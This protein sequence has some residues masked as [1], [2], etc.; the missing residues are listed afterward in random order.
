MKKECNVMILSVVFLFLV[1]SIGFVSAASGV[2]VYVDGK[3]DVPD[4]CCNSDNDCCQDNHCLSNKDGT[5]DC[6]EL[7]NKYDYGPPTSDK[8]GR[9]CRSG[10]NDPCP[11]FGS[12]NKGGTEITK[13]S[14]RG[15]DDRS[16]DTYYCWRSGQ[17]K[18]Y[19]DG[20]R[21]WA[22]YCEPGC[23]PLTSEDCS[24]LGYECG[25]PYD[26][27]CEGVFNCGT[28]DSGYTCNSSGKCKIISSCEES[29]RIMKLQST[30]SSKGALWN[31]P[32]YNVDI[33][34]DDIFGETYN[35]ADP[36]GCRGNMNNP[37][38]TVVWLESFNNSLAST[39]KEEDYDVPVCYG[40]M[41]CRYTTDSCSSNEEVVLKLS[42]TTDALMSN[43]SG[44]YPLKICCK[45]TSLEEIYWTDNNN[46]KLG[47]YDPVNLKDLV[48]VVV[49]GQGLKSGE[50]N[51]KIKK[52]EE[53]LG[54]DWL[55]PDPI[56]AE[57]SEK[58]YLKW[59]AGENQSGN[60]SSGLYYSIVEINGIEKSTEDNPEPY[61]YLNVLNEEN[62]K[63]PSIHIFN[64]TNRGIYFLKEQ[65]N[66]T[67]IA[68]DPDDDF[69][70]TWDLG[71]GV[72]KTGDSIN[73]GNLSF[74][75]DY[76]EVDEL[77]QKN[78]IVEA[79]DERGAKSRDAVSILI[80]NSSYV[81]AYIDEPGWKEHIDSHKVDFDASG[82]YAVDTSW[83]SGGELNIEC[84]AGNCPTESAGCPQ[85]YAFT[86]PIPVQN[87]PQGYDDL[88]FE[89]IFDNNP[90][91]KIS[92]FG[93]VTHT[94]AFGQVG[95]HEVNLTV[96]DSAK[97]HAE[98]SL[99]FSF[100]ACGD[101]PDDWPGTSDSCWWEDD[102][103]TVIN[104][105]GDCWREYGVSKSNR[106]RKQQSCCP[107]ISGVEYTCDND[108]GSD[109]YGMCLGNVNPEPSPYC[110]A[111]DGDENSCSNPDNW[112]VAVDYYESLPAD[113][114]IYC[115][116]SDPRSSWIDSS[117]D[118][119][120]WYECGCRYDSESS[121]CSQFK[122]LHKDCGT[123][124]V[125]T[126]GRCIYKTTFDDSRCDVT[127]FME[128]IINY[129]WIGDSED[130]PLGCPID[131]ARYQKPCVDSVRLSFFTLF[132]FVMALMSISMIYY[133]I[134]ITSKKKS[135][136][137]L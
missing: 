79:V 2:W 22:C 113:E 109:T 88:Y 11:T 10:E 9:I 76:D 108:T 46:T 122:E 18:D 97:T 7:C 121:N 110:S 134:F 66:F 53:L 94:R 67:L 83:L 137:C 95:N 132:N 38:N 28:C 103:L 34:Y 41:I 43:R 98:F 89:W 116:S 19:D 65:I 17:K 42:E 100:P 62:N 33:C 91:M 1:I 72:K 126:I 12:P 29:Q 39:Q 13:S 20:D 118:C 74:I 56:I 78:I 92:G 82:T 55:S 64:L 24:D 71:N 30:E 90:N 48:R 77:G 86:C 128:E 45:L 63:P 31:Y 75:Y 102:G 50:L 3:E 133:L 23:I 125:N 119:T 58:G 117:D 47:T 111:Y 99:H 51:I 87:T 60:F 105:T 69:N 16:G 27:G 15:D 85:G 129:Q 70:Y 136:Q 115:D 135:G 40:D 96:N 123:N 124:G 101:C 25:G 44:S 68:S 61:K 80:V 6:E 114:R 131:P 37:S 35:K 130:R 59:R 57:T 52:K 112:N 36:H 120:Y 4:N 106:E 14:S 84:I 21:L 127:G 73:W 5:M 81:L 49:R 54:I 32:D 104:S 107:D 26:D 8:K 93:L